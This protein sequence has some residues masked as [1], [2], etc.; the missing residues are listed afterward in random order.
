M[1]SLL[2][3]VASFFSMA[4]RLS[5]RFLVE[6]QTEISI[7]KSHI[8]QRQS[9]VI[10]ASHRCIIVV[11]VVIVSTCRATRHSTGNHVEKNV[12]TLYE[13]QQNLN[14]I[15]PDVRRAL[16]RRAGRFSV[17]RGIIDCVQTAC[18]FPASATAAASCCC[19]LHLQRLKA[20]LRERAA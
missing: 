20:Q 6:N 5:K 18:S 15:R 17:S 4:D 11:V 2:T 1:F 12:T 14:V 3:K 16:C 13:H 7:R 9:R 10:G 8:D 19:Y